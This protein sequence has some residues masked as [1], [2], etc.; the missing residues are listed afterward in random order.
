MLDWWKRR[1]ERKDFERQVQARQGRARMKRHIT[2]QR[3]MLGKL[4]EMMRRALLLKDDRQFRTLA[5]QYI[6]TQLDIRRWERNLLA[7]DSLEARRDQ[8]KATRQF[9][10][11]MQAMSK[12]I[13][14]NADPAELA[15]M[16][17][18]LQM[19]LT[20]AQTMEQFLDT[21]MDAIDE[22]V[23][24]M[25]GLDE[26][27]MGKA[28]EALARD[29][30][31]DMNHE[32]VSSSVESAGVRALADEPSSALDQQIDELIK[33]LEAELRNQGKQGQ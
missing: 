27:D 33:H 19:A 4:R 6:W 31:A 13:L 7:F 16:E 15:R 8:V 23:F 17:Q 30:L 29:L 2:R 32:A 24:G 25:E 11:S 12:S 3:Q 5:K 14:A 9:L 28:M 22:S 26:L 1:Q 20:R 10:E 18:D 21:M